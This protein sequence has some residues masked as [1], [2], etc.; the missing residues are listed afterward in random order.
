MDEEI[1]LSA[2]CTVEIHLAGKK[3][4]LGRL[5]LTNEKML[6]AF[7]SFNRNGRVVPYYYQKISM[8]KKKKGLLGNYLA[9]RYDHALVNFKYFVPADLNAVYN[10]LLLC[11]VKKATE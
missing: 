5:V 1:V 9:I 2:V 4:Y 8:L 10:K 7:N 6:F 3:Q 11:L